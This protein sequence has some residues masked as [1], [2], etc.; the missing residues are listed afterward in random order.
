M[1][2]TVLQNTKIIQNICFELLSDIDS[3]CKTNNIG[4][5][6]DGGTLLGAVRHKGFIPWDDDV[7]IC[8]PFSQ[9]ERIKNCISKYIDDRPDKLLFFHQTR[10]LSL[11]EFYGKITYFK[12]GAFPIRI[13]ITPVKILPAHDRILMEDRSLTQI[14]QLYFYGKSKDQ[15]MILATHKYLLPSNKDI[16]IARQDFLNYYASF[17]QRNEPNLNKLENENYEVGYIYGDILVQKSRV[18]FK[19][20]DIFPLKKIQFETGEFSA[21]NNEEMYLKLLYGEN[22]LTP[23]PPHLQVATNRFLLKN[24]SLNKNRIGRLV[25]DFYLSALKNLSIGKGKFWRIINKSVSFFVLFTKYLIALRFRE[26]RSIIIFSY[27][28]VTK[29]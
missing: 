24:N 3:I 7:D 23:P 15:S 25:E 1:D 4:Y 20:N 28:Q 13:D 6:I 10:V 14:A 18:N 2:K 9:F 26:I 12:D 22:Y 8:V 5:W 19:S 11:S 16:K 27:L 17:I 21:P 29:K